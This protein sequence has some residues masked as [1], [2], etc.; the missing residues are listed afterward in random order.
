[1]P[2]GEGFFSNPNFAYLYIN[3]L[4]MP[5]VIISY[6]KPETLKVLEVL[7]EPLAFEI[8]ISELEDVSRQKAVDAITVPADKEADI[9]QLFQAFTGKNLDAKTLREQLWRTKK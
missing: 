2:F 9:T 7:A 6:E 1:M 3:T 8:V 5:E 4:I